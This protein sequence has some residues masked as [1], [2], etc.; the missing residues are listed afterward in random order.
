MIDKINERILIFVVAF[1][2]EKNILNVLS[3]IPPSIS[4]LNHEILIID[5]CSGDETFSTTVA[6]LTQFDSLNVKVL[7]NP[8]KQGYGGNQK[9]GYHY[10]IENG[11]DLVVLLHGDGQYSPEML[12]EMISTL[13]TGKTDAVIGSRMMTGFSALWEG[14]PLY[15]FLGNKFLT[16]I[17]NRLLNSQLSEFHSGYRAYRVQTLS[18]IPFELNTNDFH[19]DTEI[20]IQLILGKF[21]IREI[22]IPTYIG[23]EIRHIKGVKYAWDVIHQTLNS[24]L[25]QMSLFY[26]RKFD[27]RRGVDKYTLK[28]GYPSSHEFAITEVG[29]NSTVLDIGC[30]DSLVGMELTKKGCWVEAID[31]E[32]SQGRD[33]LIKFTKLNLNDTQAPIP[34]DQFDY[35][36]LL[37]VLEHLEDPEAFVYNIRKQSKGKLPK[38]IVSVP[39]IGWFTMR[40]QLLMGRFNYGARG[41]LDLGHRRL[42]TFS[43]I[44]GIF[45]QAGF[46]I[47][48]SMGVPAPYPLAIGNNFVSRILVGINQALV[49]VFP[50][51][52][53]YQI[54]LVTVPMPTV[55]ELLQTSRKSSEKLIDEISPTL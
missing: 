32:D 10:A 44:K 4:K 47:V 33:K 45:K 39:N 15:K 42:F 53:S 20:L 2:A 41:I 55:N 54:F 49:K 31:C 34:I 19:F 25:H 12:D 26:E 17:Q 13:S 11:F 9:L 51:L 16:F 52:F 1:N 43:T 46:K 29:S 24:K 36:L 14:M 18:K 21:V 6:S 40:L 38:I 48:R 22:P 35:I 23:D 30:G 3:R 50:S 5:D 37:D 7:F 28:K 27:I 8:E